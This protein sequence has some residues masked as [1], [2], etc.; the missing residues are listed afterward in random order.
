MVRL[1][2]DSPRDGPSER[3]KTDYPALRIITM[4]T[5]IPAFALSLPYGIDTGTVVPALG[6][7]PMSFSA[8]M[9]MVHLTGWARSRVGNLLME[10]FCSC[11]LLGVLIAFW[12]VL[13]HKM[14]KRP[15]LLM[16]G[17][18]ATVPM[19]VNS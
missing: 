2:L 14:W 11:F 15:S 4:L 18:Y 1:P 9:G 17:S 6:I 5:W 19:M 16:L 3:Q 7:M 12:V 10:I 13:S 8:L